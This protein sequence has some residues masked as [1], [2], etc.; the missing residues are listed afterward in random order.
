MDLIPHYPILLILTTS[1]DAYLAIPVM[2]KNYLLM[3]VVMETE[4]VKHLQPFHLS[5]H[6]VSMVMVKSLEVIELLVLTEEIVETALTDLELNLQM[7]HSFCQVEM[8]LMEEIED[9][10]VIPL[11]LE[12]D[13]KE[14]LEVEIL[15]GPLTMDEEVLPDLEETEETVDLEAT[16]ETMDLEAIEVILDFEDLLE[17]EVIMEEMVTEETMDLEEMVTEETMD[18]EATMLEMLLEVVQLETED[19]PTSM[20]ITEAKEAVDLALVPTEAVMETEATAIQETEKAADSMGMDSPTVA[21][22]LLRPAET[23]RSELARNLLLSHQ[24]PDQLHL[25]Q[26]CLASSQRAAMLTMTFMMVRLTTGIL[27]YG[28]SLVLEDLELS[29]RHWDLRFVRDLA[30][31]DILQIVINSMNVIGT[32]G[33]KSSLFTSSLVL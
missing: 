10:I 33:L 7:S 12:G 16:E 8:L 24:S 23:M 14:Q 4:M 2:K 20:R 5:Q 28:R 3:A 29:M 32:N 25:S 13:R 31:S 1:Q 15:E 9:P 6:L 18:L 22:D 11:D 27:E 26:L 19:H 17:T 21:I 30:C